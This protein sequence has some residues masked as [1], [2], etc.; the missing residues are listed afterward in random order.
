MSID[1]PSPEDSSQMPD[2]LWP[3]RADVLRLLNAYTPWDAEES[4]HKVSILSFLATSKHPFEPTSFAP[5]H[6][7]VSALICD[8]ETRQVLLIYHRRL[9]RW[10]QPGGHVDSVDKQMVDT[11]IREV[12]EEVGLQLVRKDAH[13]FDVDVH[14]IPPFGEAPR[15]LHFDFRFLFRSPKCQVVAM[16]DATDAHWVPIQEAIAQN[17]NTGATRL[18]TKCEREL[19]L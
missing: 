14:E 11:A 1:M 15:H 8:S 13:L 10:I 4:R 18:F 19:A 9:Q 16:S 6:L 17:S 2:H 3:S 7:T 12:R 5:G